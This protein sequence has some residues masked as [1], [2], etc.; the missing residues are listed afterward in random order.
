M[1]FTDLVCLTDSYDLC[2]EDFKFYPIYEQKGLYDHQDGILGLAPVQTKHAHTHGPSFV[3]A[4]KKQHVIDR[5]LI[6]LFV[7]KFHSKKHEAIIGDYSTDFLQDND[8]HL[9]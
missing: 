4:L 6:S 1:G 2:I 5:A 8:E 3:H 9:I 7:S